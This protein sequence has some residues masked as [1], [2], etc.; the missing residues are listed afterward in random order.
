[1]KHTLLD[2]DLHYDHIKIFCDNTSTIHMTKNANQH[3]K[4][5]H[6]KIRYHFLRDHFE[7]GD[8]DIDY[9]STDFYLLIFSLNYLIS[10]DFPLYVVNSMFVLLTKEFSY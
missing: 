7:K 10:I 2:Y 5:K 8:I 3:S 1:M 6:I 9:V 4:T